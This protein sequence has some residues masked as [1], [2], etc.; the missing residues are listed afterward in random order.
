MGRLDFGT[1][2]ARDRAANHLGGNRA[3][4]YGHDEDRFVHGQYREQQGPWGGDLY[5]ATGVNFSK[6]MASFPGAT[7]D[8]VMQQCFGGG[9]APGFAA[10]IPKATVPKSG[11]TLTAATNWNQTAINTRIRHTLQ[12]FTSAYNQSLSAQAGVGMY[13]HYLSGHQRLS[14]GRLYA[15]PSAAEHR[16]PRSLRPT[17]RITRRGQGRFEDPTYASPDA[18]VGTPSGPTRWAP[19]PCEMWLPRTSLRC[20]SPRIQQGS[21]M[22]ASPPTSTGST[23]P[24]EP[25][26]LRKTSSSCTATPQGRQRPPAALRST[27]PRR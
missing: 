1:G 23:I 11:Y 12:N 4:R 18:L 7:I 9:F 26:F 27:A 22:P 8:V 10:A 25:T 14:A 6:T 17:R 15:A 21:A 16:H 13:N 3:A 2:C 19:T 5:A 20:C 24:S